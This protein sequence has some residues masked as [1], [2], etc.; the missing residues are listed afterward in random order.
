MRGD[1]ALR[2]KSKAVASSR[3]PLSARPLPLAGY[4]QTRKALRPA[5]AELAN[6]QLPH[7]LSVANHAGSLRQR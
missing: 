4:R 3:Q 7:V 6:E 5:T 1:Q 2:I